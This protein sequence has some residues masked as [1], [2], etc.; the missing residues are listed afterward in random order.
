MN[1]KSLFF[2]PKL[3]INGMSQCLVDFKLFDI[4]SHML[5][6]VYLTLSEIFAAASKNSPRDKRCEM[7]FAWILIAQRERYINK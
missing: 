4:L 5:R 7:S 1:I 2:F 3:N 6:R